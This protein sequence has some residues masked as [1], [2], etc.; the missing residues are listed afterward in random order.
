MDHSNMPRIH[1]SV[2]SHQLNITPSLRPIYQKVRC[3]HPDRQR[4]IQAEVEKL[5]EV[6]FIKE[7]EYSEWLVNVVVVPKK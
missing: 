7:V 1:P 2:A 6:G 4:F 5:L 3:F